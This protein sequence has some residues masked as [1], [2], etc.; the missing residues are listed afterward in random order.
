MRIFSD[1]NIRIGGMSVK[2]YIIALIAL[3]IL[4]LPAPSNAA[5]K[6]DFSKYGPVD[7]NRHVRETLD[8]VGTDTA[9][10]ENAE[11]ETNTR[12]MKMFST[13]MANNWLITRS[14][15]FGFTGFDQAVG[16]LQNTDALQKEI[17]LRDKTAAA[18]ASGAISNTQQSHIKQEIGYVDPNQRKQNYIIANSKNIASELSKLSKMPGF[19]SDNTLFMRVSYMSFLILFLTF[20]LRLAN[21]LF[22]GLTGRDEKAQI[23]EAFEAVFR[24]ILF[25]IYIYMLKWG[26]MG[27]LLFSEMLRNVILGISTVNTSSQLAHDLHLMSLLKGQLVQMDPN[28]TLLSLMQYGA[29][30]AVSSVMSY[31]CYVITGAIIFTMV[32]LGDVMMAITAITGPMVLAISMIKG[33]ERWAENFV[34]SAFQFSLYMPIAGLYMLTMAMIH[35]I[36][37]N[38][39]FIAYLTISYAFFFG[40]KKIPNLS[41]ALS[42]AAFASMSTAAVGQMFMLGQG[43]ITKG[44]Q[45]SMNIRS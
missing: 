3:F 43:T 42:G 13:L 17:E 26:I 27:L 1:K 16:L 18:A 44:L 32:L 37:P 38:I 34:T 24:L 22:K 20:A 33:F 5:D 9:A 7:I 8:L 39:S 30:R 28:V 29:G 31:I 19:S 11:L 12:V 15:V 4:V 10:G 23:S 14:V 2:R 35:A 45:K 25:V 6:I 41:E 21:S 36:V 40:A